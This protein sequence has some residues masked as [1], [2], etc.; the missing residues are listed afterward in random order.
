MLGNGYVNAPIA[1]VELLPRD[2]PTGHLR[3]HGPRAKKLPRGKR[4]PNALLLC[5]LCSVLCTLY[6]LLA[7]TLWQIGSL[8]VSLI[9]VLAKGEII[10]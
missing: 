2:E 7:T 4:L 10:C 8:L 3:S 6:T 9:L 1:G 5:A